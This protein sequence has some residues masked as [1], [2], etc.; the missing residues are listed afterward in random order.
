MKLKL[1][2]VAVHSDGRKTVVNDTNDSEFLDEIIEKRDGTIW[3]G[4]ELCDLQ[5]QVVK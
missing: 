3:I 5:V 4:S 2:L 1:Q